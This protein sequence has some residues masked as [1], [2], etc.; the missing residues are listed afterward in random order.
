MTYDFTITIASINFIYTDLI[1]IEFE[2][3][4]L[5]SDCVGNDILSFFIELLPASLVNILLDDF[6]VLDSTQPCLSED[7][8][9]FDN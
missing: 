1:K 2:H 8:C 7:I 9:S 4:T 5:I 3:A 6:I